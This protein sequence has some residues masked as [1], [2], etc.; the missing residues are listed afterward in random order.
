GRIKSLPL[1]K[2]LEKMQRVRRLWEPWH[3]RWKKDPLNPAHWEV[4]FMLE[5]W[6]VA[7]FAPDLPCP[8]KISEKKLEEMLGATG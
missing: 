8:T 3:A 7:V 4:G 5:D 6:R 2:D 1:A